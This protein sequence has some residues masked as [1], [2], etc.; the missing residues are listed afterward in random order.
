M[1]IEHVLT[2]IDN[3]H[4]LAARYNVPW[5]DIVSYNGLEYPYTLTSIEAYRKLYASGYLKITR[6]LAT[7]EVT[8]YAG[9]TFMTETDSQGIQKVY[10][11]VEDLYMP[12]GT[13]TGY[14]FVRCTL[15]GTFGNTIQNTIILRGN[16]RSSLGPFLSEL[17]VTNEQPFTN[18][19]DAK[20]RIT[21]Q[22]LLIPT[23]DDV[24]DGAHA[25]YNADNYL[26]Q[27]G[28]EDLAVDVDGEIRDDGLGDLGSVIGVDNI[29]QA[30]RNRLMC[31]RGGLP[32]HPEYGSDL[33]TLIGKAQ[34]PYINSLVSVYINEA[35]LSDDRI[36]SVSVDRV[37]ISGTVIY[38]DLTVKIVDS[39]QA[40]TL[41]DMVLS[42]E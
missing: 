18:G 29:A 22:T 15:Y 28:G 19:T 39:D 23:P 33:H 2:D 38:V 40:L 27:L 11:M 41:Q 7:T 30:I 17:T 8:I 5:E 26:N 16:V 42:F 21:G 35:L 3:V 10:E 36:A 37:R 34:L 25:Q 9:S 4:N 24:I 31:R 6:A 12:A 32:K 1:P 20:V 13:Y 14:A